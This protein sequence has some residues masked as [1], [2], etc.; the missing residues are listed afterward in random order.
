MSILT[1]TARTGEHDVMITTASP[2]S[3]TP[4]YESMQVACLSSS[5]KKRME[6]SRRQVI[7]TLLFSNLW[8]LLMTTIPVLANNPHQINQFYNV[9]DIIRILEPGL[10]LMFQCTLVFLS[11]VFYAIEPSLTSLASSNHRRSMFI[12]L[13]FILSVYVYQQGAAFHSAA[14]MFKHPVES[15]LVSITN[16]PTN[17]NTTSVE[18]ELQATFVWMEVTWEHII[19]HYM[20]AL[21][22]K[23]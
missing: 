1:P 12:L 7:Y 8:V 3:A 21:G 9:N 11:G 18:K 6:I 14:N 10:T 19:S 23:E 16:G 20:Y 15:L 17:T 4:V 22:K 5:V 13:F 2:S